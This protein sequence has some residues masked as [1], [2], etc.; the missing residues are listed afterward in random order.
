MHNIASHL[1]TTVLAIEQVHLPLHFHQQSKGECH[2]R[3]CGSPLH[4]TMKAPDFQHNLQ[5]M[6]KKL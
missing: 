1:R 4:T 6:K 5:A 3:E 2:R